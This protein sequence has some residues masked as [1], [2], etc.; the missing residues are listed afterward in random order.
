MLATLPNRSNRVNDM[1]GREPVSL[2][3]LGIASLAAMKLPAF[4]YEVR[5]CRSMDR[6]VDATAAKQRR[7]G[8]VDNSIDTQGRDIG[9]EDFEPHAADLACAQVQA[10]VEAGTPLSAKSCCNSPAWNI[11]RMMSQPPANS[12]FT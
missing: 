11:S 7:V 1:T 5:T 9:D 6:A 12:P 4:H 10:A 8:G 2:G 3:D